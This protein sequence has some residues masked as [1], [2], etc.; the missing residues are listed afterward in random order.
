MKVVMGG[1]VSGHGAGHSVRRLG[2]RVTQRFGAYCNPEQVG[3]VADPLRI[4]QAEVSYDSAAG[5]AP[6]IRS[7]RSL[8][9]TLRCVAASMPLRQML[10]ATSIH[11]RCGAAACAAGMAWPRGQRETTR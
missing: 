6:C 4:N 3:D 9:L 11:R 8:C 7:T 10:Y 5:Y 1:I 2:R